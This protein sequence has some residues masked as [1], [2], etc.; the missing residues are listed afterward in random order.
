MTVPNLLRR[1]AGVFAAGG[2]WA[3]SVTWIVW[4]P[5]LVFEVTFALWLIVKGVAGSERRETA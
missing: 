1:R 4:L 3:S 2:N 5:L